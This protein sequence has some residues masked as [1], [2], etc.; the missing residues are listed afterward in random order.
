MSTT[1]WAMIAYG[2]SGALAL[3]LLYMS[4]PSRWY[5]HVL[6]V[7][8]ALALGLAPIPAKLNTPQMSIVIGVVFFFLFLWG[9]AAPLFLMRRRRA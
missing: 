8:L 1:T 7:V 6:S 2:S 4:G 3:L 5:L 9:I